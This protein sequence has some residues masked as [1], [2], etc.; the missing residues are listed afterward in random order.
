MTKTNESGTFLTTDLEKMINRLAGVI[1]SK[2]VTDARSDI[3]EIH[4]LAN[5]QRSP[6]Q[7][8]RDVQSLAATSFDMNLEHRI[9]SVAQIADD[10]MLEIG[11]RLKIKDFDVSWAGNKVTMSVTLAGID[12]LAK[13]TATGMN[14]APSR[15]L[16]AARACI[17]ALHEFLTLEST[18]D[19]IDIQKLRIAGVDSYSVAVSYND[20]GEDQIL[21]GASIVRDGDYNAIIAA[22]L[23][24]V[25]RLVNR[26]M[27]AGQ[28]G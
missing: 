5:Y 8:V 28:P 22:T 17:A 16:A 13:G 14:T 23:D 19:V 20:K 10:S 18:F 11:I 9:I 24:A 1:L 7:I 25:N 27:N 12:R 3:S 21:L 2:V 15:N 26:L 4:I 6:K